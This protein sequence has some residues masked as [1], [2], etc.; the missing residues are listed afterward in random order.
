MQR[1]P[2]ARGGKL[3]RLL[4]NLEEPRRVEHV[5]IRAGPHGKVPQEFAVDVL[6]FFDRTKIGYE[7][8]CMGRLPALDLER[9]IVLAHDRKPALEAFAVSRELADR[10]LQVRGARAP[11]KEGAEV[12][13]EQ[14]IGKRS[15]LFRFFY[16]WEMDERT[17]TKLARDGR[18]EQG[19]RRQD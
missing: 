6:R 17:R 3:L 19:F 15:S 10:F 5:K 14:L 8:H 18:S 13:R 7:H 11:Q 1:G 2:G 12:V 4:G 16:P 9:A